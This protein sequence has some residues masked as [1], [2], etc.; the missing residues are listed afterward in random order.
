VVFGNTTSITEARG[1]IVAGASGN[2][3][4]TIGHMGVTGLRLL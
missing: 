2:C 1:A 4:E 3:G